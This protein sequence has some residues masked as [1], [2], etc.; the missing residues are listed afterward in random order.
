MKKII[1]YHEWI[2]KVGGIETAVYNLA[3]H[4]VLNDYEVKVAFKGAEDSSSIIR[5]SEFADTVK[6]SN[7]NLECDICLMASNHFIPDRIKAKKYLQW[8]HSDYEKYSLEL[9]NIG[10]IDKYIAVSQNSA[11]VAKKLFGIECDVIYNL[12]DPDFTNFKKPDLKLVSISRISPEKGFSRMLALCEALRSKD[13]GFVWDII[14]DNSQNK[15]YEDKIKAMFKDYNEVSFVGYKSDIRFGLTTSDY[16]VLLSDFEGCPL[17][18][19][20]ALS[21][22]VPCILSSYKGADELVQHGQNGYILPLDMNL[23]DNVLDD[24]INK[25][26]K[27]K[28]NQKGEIK[29]WLKHLK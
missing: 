2:P 9:K 20:E 4:L 17:S 14:G 10:K 15:S 8:I 12:V 1:I 11:D 22:G 21:F 16:L 26:P 25:K 24:I 19:L 23:S 3:K 13:V 7:Q 6:L 29:S 27:F 5:Y 28:F 18:V